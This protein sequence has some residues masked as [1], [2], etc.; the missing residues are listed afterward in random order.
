VDALT[1][2]RGTL[3]DRLAGLEIV[4]A[5]TGLELTAN[6]GT[7]SGGTF[8]GQ[9]ATTARAEVDL[10]LPPGISADEAEALVVAAARSAVP[11]GGAKVRRIK[12]WDADVTSPTTAIAGSWRE[13]WGALGPEP[14]EYAIRLPASDA[15]RW[16]RL[17]TPSLCYGPQPTYS[18][19]ID[20]YAEEDEV[21]R[22]AALYAL[23]A[24]RFLAP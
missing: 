19:A 5:E 23:S 3:G 22:C 17:G 4:D 1:G 21:V 8:I 15:S 11:G 20:D 18:A 16:R 9:V 10:R 6:V 24:L 13:A 12:G 14:L 2:R 7:L